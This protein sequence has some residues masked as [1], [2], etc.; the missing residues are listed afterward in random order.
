MLDGRDRAVPSP[1]G[2]HWVYCTV[3]I[4]QM[5]ALASIPCCIPADEAGE[6]AVHH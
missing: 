5:L 4:I 1:L 2:R 6:A 3:T